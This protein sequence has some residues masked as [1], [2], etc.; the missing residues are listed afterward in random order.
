MVSGQPRR[1]DPGSPE[2]RGSWAVVIRGIG[3][4]PSP[5]TPR[6][7]HEGWGRQAEG[8]RGGREVRGA[9]GGQCGT[10]SWREGQ[11]RRRSPGVRPV[12]E[13]QSLGC[14]AQRSG[15]WESWQLRFAPGGGGVGPT[16]LQ[17]L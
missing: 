4:L 10:R 15:Q 6:A 16:V 17:E 2:P 13:P 14:C 3:L 5:P 9:G 8:S 1:R 11:R 12:G 7:S